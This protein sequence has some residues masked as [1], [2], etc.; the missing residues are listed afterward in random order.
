MHGRGILSA[1]GTHAVREFRL[2]A[3][4][5]T[6]PSPLACALAHRAAVS[7]VAGAATVRGLVYDFGLLATRIAIGMD[8]R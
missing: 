1:L 7:A 8:D 2:K 4:G 6:F 5:I 3:L